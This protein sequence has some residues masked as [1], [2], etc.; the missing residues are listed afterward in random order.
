MTDKSKVRKG[1]DFIHIETKHKVTFG[2]WQEDGTAFCVSKTKG[3]VVVPQKDFLE[4]Y[5]SVA[6]MTKRQRERRSGQAW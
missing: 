3:F 1:A 6:E 5:I 2:Q 4:Q